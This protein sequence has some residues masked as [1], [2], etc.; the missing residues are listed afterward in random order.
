M[1]TTSVP[2]LV[3]RCCSS[4]SVG[5]LH[6]G[7]FSLHASGSPLEEQELSDEF[8]SHSHLY[9]TTLTALVSTTTNF[10]RV[11]HLAYQ[12]LWDGE[13]ADQ[14]ELIFIVP[15]PKADARLHC[16]RDLADQMVDWSEQERRLFTHEFVYEWQIPESAV[17]HRI[18]M[19]T[20]LRRGLNLEQLCGTVESEEFPGMIDFQDLIRANWGN[21]RLFGRECKAGTAACLFDIGYKAGMAACL[22]GF[23]S[24]T[25][26]ILDE[27]LSLI[28]YRN[29]FGLVEDGIEDALSTYASCIVDGLEAYE[30][31]FEDL[32]EAA[33]MLHHEYA[34]DADE[35]ILNYSDEPADV[36]HALVVLEKRYRDCRAA[37]EMRVAEIYLHIGY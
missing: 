9:G 20:L 16:A 2:G 4:A 25:S 14:T 10:L 34:T 13:A 28:A 11:L 15:D 30:A 31:E 21:L 27:I 36:D 22:F 6:S 19:A 17:A 5:R 32:S 33:A 3:F 37:L 23:H 29:P 1:E 24:L 7:K 26:R 18:T 12:K 8:E 35:V